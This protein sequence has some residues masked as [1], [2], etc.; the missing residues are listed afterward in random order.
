MIPYV[1]KLNLTEPTEE[2]GTMVH[3]FEQFEVQ[4]DA[5]LWIY[6]DGFI[7]FWTL[8]ADSMLANSVFFEPI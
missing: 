2:G 4:C 6:T 7:E 3:P 5:H 1:P 8:P